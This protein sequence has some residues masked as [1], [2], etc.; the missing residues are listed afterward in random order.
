M[1]E[2]LRMENICKTI[3]NPQVAFFDDRL[4][5]TSH[6]DLPNGLTKEEIFNGV[7]KP[8]NEQ[9]RMSS[10]IKYL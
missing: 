9:F 1:K 5:I 7:G 6:G 3:I 2:R 10:L 4:E 8:R